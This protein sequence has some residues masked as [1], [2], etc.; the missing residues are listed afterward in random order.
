MNTVHREW[1]EPFSTT[2]PD[3]G[4]RQINLHRIDMTLDFHTG[5][6]FDRRDEKTGTPRRS[7]MGA[8][9]ADEMVNESNDLPGQGNEPYVAVEVA[10]Q[11]Q[12]A[13]AM[14]LAVWTHAQEHGFDGSAPEHILHITAKMPNRRTGAME[15]IHGIAAVPVPITLQD[16]IL[17]APARLILAKPLNLYLVNHEDYIFAPDEAVA[18]GIWRHIWL[19]PDDQYPDNVAIELQDPAGTLGGLERDISYPE[20][21]TVATFLAWQKGPGHIGSHRRES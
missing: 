11:E 3:G 1:D 19:G 4:T 2:T 15:D 8:F 12:A 7:I 18:E 13:K 16:L 6:M 17:M 20:D 21:I 9:R 10:V 5:F 14:I